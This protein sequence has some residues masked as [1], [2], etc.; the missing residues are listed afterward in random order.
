[1]TTHWR[2]ADDLARKFPRIRV[3]ARALYYKQGKMYTCA[4]IT[5]GIDLA[6]A[7]IEEDHGPGVALA[8]ARESQS[9]PLQIQLGSR[10]PTRFAGRSSGDSDSHRAATR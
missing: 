5:A 6:L 8:V 4:G 10:A 1:M 9:S 7:L 3:D 2:F